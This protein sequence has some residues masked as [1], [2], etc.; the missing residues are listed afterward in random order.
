[1]N[2]VVLDLEAT[3]WDQWE[4]RQN[5]TIEIGA[6][7][8]NDEKEIISEFQRF[9]KPLRFPK[10]SDFCKELTT[11]KQTDIDQASHF[12]EVI[13]AFKKWFDCAKGDYILCSWGFYDKKQFANDCDLN[14]LDK[15]WL[16]PHISLKHQHGKLKNLPRP[17]GMKRALQLE[18]MEIEGT[19]H[20]GIDDA[21]NIS[22]LFLKYFDKWE[23]PS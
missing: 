20:R 12:Y 9:I 10:L 8:I 14:N 2:Y 11:I 4:K 18:K 13:E 1:M 6:I 19:H 16:K 5:E 17:I 23:F 22:K 3:C 21:R 7:L 15:S